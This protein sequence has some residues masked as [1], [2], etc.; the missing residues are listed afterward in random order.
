MQQ[1]MKKDTS[2]PC[3][4]TPG[5]QGWFNSKKKSKQWDSQY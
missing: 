5:K 4:F 3:I 2:G 1:H